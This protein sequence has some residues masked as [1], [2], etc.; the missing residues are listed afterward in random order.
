MQTIAETVSACG[1][2][3]SCDEL[4]ARGFTLR[5]IDKAVAAH[6]VTRVRRGWVAA[7]NAPDAVVRAVK[8]RGIVSCVS[9]L[10]AL[11][12]WTADSH[13]ARLLH[14]RVPWFDKI[15]QDSAARGLHVH[16]SWPTR[17][18]APAQGGID[19]IEWAL[20]HATM[21]QPK[22][23]AIASL[24][25]ALHQGL[26]GNGRLLDVL[27]ALPRCYRDYARAIAPAESGIETHTRLGLRAAGIA[28][29]SQLSIAGVGDVDLV[30]GDRLV[31][32]VDG[33]RWHSDRR[34][35]REDKRR[36]LALVAM[37]Y[38]VIRLSYEQVMLQWPRVLEVI[39]GL[40][41]RGEHRWAARHG[42]GVVLVP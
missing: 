21:C 2:V 39:R 8:S 19:S 26:I 1:G 37:G 30:V 17:V 35:F 25:S 3:A 22:F 38:L 16:R 5:A 40:M 23:D 9:V 42:R 28:C 29:R 33:R 31:I 20:V 36:D 7:A 10:R 27:G 4:A 13:D 32:E 15:A 34:S 14:I 11:E 18:P 24:E 41:Q 12:V 6:H